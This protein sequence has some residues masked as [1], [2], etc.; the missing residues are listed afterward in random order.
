M[1]KLSAS[2]TFA[3]L[4][5]LDLSKLDKPNITIMKKDVI[6]DL[7]VHLLAKVYSPPA[8]PSYTPAPTNNKDNPII[9]ALQ[10]LSDELKDQISK[11]EVNIVNRAADLEKSILS[12]VSHVE[13]KLQRGESK[14]EHINTSVRHDI[15]DPIV[16]HSENFIDEDFSAELLEL[17]N[18]L[19]FTPEGGHSVVH[20]GEEYH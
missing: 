4:L 8:P 6:A 9:S 3:E 15:C 1:K 2:T 7:T 20:F 17:C 12:K 10:T 11:A 5:T 18:S 14:T 19:T 13:D 16:K